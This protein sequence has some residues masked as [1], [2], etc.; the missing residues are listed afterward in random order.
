MKTIASILLM[1]PLLGLTTSDAGQ[2]PN[3]EDFISKTSELKRTVFSAS[4]PKAL[5]NDPYVEIAVK[6]HNNSKED[7]GYKRY[8]KYVDYELKLVNSKGIAARYTN[9]GEIAYSPTRG[10]GS[11]LAGAKLPPGKHFDMKLN[12]SMIFD[13]TMTDEYTLSVRR[14]VRMSDKTFELAVEGITFTV[15]PDT[16]W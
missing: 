7:M 6:V 15:I 5:F 2:R 11:G 14:R 10:S 12:L 9:Y 1:V 3:P 13:L 16:S 4:L 8:G